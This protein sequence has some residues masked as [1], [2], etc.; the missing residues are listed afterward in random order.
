MDDLEVCVLNEGEE[1]WYEFLPER[2]F[3]IKFYRARGFPLFKI[4]KC[5]EESYIDCLS[6]HKRLLAVQVEEKL[7][8]K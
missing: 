7:R 4:I 6:K 8:T 2:D 1:I 3:S 5:K